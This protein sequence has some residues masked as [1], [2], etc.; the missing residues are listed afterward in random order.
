MEKY[1]TYTVYE[2]TLTGE[3]KRIPVGEELE[4]S[5]ADEWRELDYDPEGEE[6]N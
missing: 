2:N 6:S 4:K 1:S 5:A 3:L